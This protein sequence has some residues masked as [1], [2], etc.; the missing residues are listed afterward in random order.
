MALTKVIREDF[1]GRRIKAITDDGDAFM[2][3]RTGVRWVVPIKSPLLHL[4]EKLKI[5]QQHK[6][7]QKH[8]GVHGSSRYFR[9]AL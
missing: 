4:E 1:T 8:G 9:P 2:G 7:Y 6:R 3:H 5:L